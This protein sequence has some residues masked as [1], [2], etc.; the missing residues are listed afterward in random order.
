MLRIW[1]RTTS[2]N[3]Q[4]V[5]WLAG[6]I[7]LDYERV[8]A[9]GPF[10]KVD[11]PAYRAMNP[12]GLVPTIADDGFV[13]WESNTICRYLAARHGAESMYPSPLQ[14]RADVERWM[15][16]SSTALAPALFPAFWGL[17]RTPAPQRDRDAIVASADKSAAALRILDAQLA[18]RPFLCGDALTLADVTCGINTYRW[19]NLDFAAA[20]YRRPAM[21]NL[22]AW[23]ERLAARP[24][25]RQAVMIP[26]T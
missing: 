22:Q 23:Y 8:D 19:F 5:L 9:G 1:G 13:L 11:E 26:I 2:S 17:V 7:G 21:P 18:G 12:N 24:A 25:Y 6:E 16:W 15:D 10:G 20:D 3:V 4:K 14:R